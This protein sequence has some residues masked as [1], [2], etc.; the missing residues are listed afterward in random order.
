MS[1][2]SANEYLVAVK[3][4]AHH[5][6]LYQDHAGR[7]FYL[8]ENRSRVYVENVQPIHQQHEQGGRATQPGRQ[9]WQGMHAPR[10]RAHHQSVPESQHG[11]SAPQQ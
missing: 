7:W 5:D 9:Q 11:R 8:D 1:S 4:D 3:T 2:D 6:T 10:Q